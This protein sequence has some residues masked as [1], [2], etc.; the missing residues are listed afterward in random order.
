MFSVPHDLFR[1]QSL[2][3]TEIRHP[4][5]NGEILHDDGVSTIMLAVDNVSLVKADVLVIDSLLSGFDMLVRMGIIRMLGRVHI[6]QSGNATFSRMKLCA[7]ATI[8]IEE[9]DF[10]AKFDEQTRAW[11]ASWKGSGNQPPNI[12]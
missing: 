6:N 1:V 11:T 12:L 7:C 8:R 2:E 5:V 3:P 4:E 9:V 10:S